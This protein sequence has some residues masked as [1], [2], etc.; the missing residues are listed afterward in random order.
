MQPEI[1]L[2]LIPTWPRNSDRCAASRREDDTPTKTIVRFVLGALLLSS[3]WNAVTAQNQQQLQYTV[4]FRTREVSPT[5]ERRSCR[6]S[7][8]RGL[9]ARYWSHHS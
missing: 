8:A 2:Q 1:W 4:V 5:L 9:P 7:Q 3:H 6:G